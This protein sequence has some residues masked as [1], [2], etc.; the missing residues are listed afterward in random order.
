MAYFACICT[1]HLTGVA[2]ITRR[3]TRRSMAQWL[4][5]ARSRFKVKL[6]LKFPACCILHLNAKCSEMQNAACQYGVDSELAPALPGPAAAAWPGAGPVCRRRRLES[7]NYK[8][9]LSHCVFVTDSHFHFFFSTP[10]DGGVTAQYLNLTWNSSWIASI[11]ADSTKTD[12]PGFAYLSSIRQ[13]RPSDSTSLKLNWLWLSSDPR[14]RR[15]AMQAEWCFV[16][17][18]FQI[19]GEVFVQGFCPSPFH[20]HGLRSNAANTISVPSVQ[21]SGDIE[22]KRFHNTLTMGLFGGKPNTASSSQVIAEKAKLFKSVPAWVTVFYPVGIH[23]NLI[24]GNR[25]LVMGKPI[26]GSHSF[27]IYP[28]PTQLLSNCFSK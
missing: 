28:S 8:H 7:F 6:L 10:P 1:P 4:H 23:Q 20:N 26:T 19:L 16:I 21:I 9:A 22:A 3:W 15:R 24:D 11:S 27:Q 14:R 18:V 13:W 12:A 5:L 2:P 17:S 25:N